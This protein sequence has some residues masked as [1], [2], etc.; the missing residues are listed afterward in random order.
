M[1][2]LIKDG[3]CIYILANLTNKLKPFK[4]IS[5]LHCCCQ[6]AG[7]L[8]WLRYRS[9]SIPLSWRLAIRR[10]RISWSVLLWICMHWGTCPV[11]LCF[12]WWWWLV[13]STW[14]WLL[15]SK[16]TNMFHHTLSWGLYTWC[17]L[18][19]T[20]LL[21]WTE[22]PCGCSSRFPPCCT[23]WLYTGDLTSWGS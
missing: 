13:V 11:G 2:I 19:C 4:L 17:L 12:L 1:C 20:H 9:L 22:C 5:F 6:L 21:R 10:R 3:L 16:G 14:Y 23:N 7:C 8:L 15:L 18:W